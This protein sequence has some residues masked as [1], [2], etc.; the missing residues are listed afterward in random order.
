[1]SGGELAALI[2]ALAFVA[3]AAVLCVLLVK[4]HGAVSSAQ[5]L[6]D[7]LHRTT[8][9]VLRELD[10]T[11]SA[12]NVEIDRVDGILASAESVAASVGN[13]AELVSTAT[14][15]PIIKGLSLLAGAGAAA[16]AI[17]KKRR[18]R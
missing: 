18:R 15:N 17:K 10:E 1:M 8:V 3:L 12:L 6:V 13:V 5:A 9:P 2:A 14:A 4:L 11:V 16:R 7:D